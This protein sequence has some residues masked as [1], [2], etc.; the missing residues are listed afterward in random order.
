MIP[1]ACGA[2][3][4][5]L[6]CLMPLSAKAPVAPRHE[7]REPGLPLVLKNSSRRRPVCQENVDFFL[8][9]AATP[10]RRLRHRLETSTAK[11][12]QTIARSQMR[13]PN[14]SLDDREKN[15]MDSS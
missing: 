13:L 10:N 4:E 15:Y 3:S 12:R 14:K 7:K 1:I 6:R 8:P 11:A 2:I 9:S 5:S